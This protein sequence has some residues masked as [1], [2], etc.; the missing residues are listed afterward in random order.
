MAASW[1]HLSVLATSAA[2]VSVT[3]FAS[4]PM[5]GAAVASFVGA[6]SF[7]PSSPAEPAL[8]T[9]TFSPTTTNDN[10][11]LLPSLAAVKAGSTNATVST[12][13]GAAVWPNQADAFASDSNTTSTG[14]LSAGVLSAG[15]FF[16]NVPGYPSK[17]TGSVDIFT[18][19]S[20]S[21]ADSALSF[22][23]QQISTDKSSFFYHKA[24]F[25][26][27]DGDGRSDVIAARCYVPQYGLRK[28]KSELLW[29][30][31]PPA[32]SGSDAAW[33]EHV[34]L[35]SGPD[36]G[37]VM[38]DLD[39]GDGSTRSPQVVA[40]E[41]FV[42]QQLALYW[43]DGDGSGNGT[44]SECGEEGGSL[45]AVSSAVI[46]DTEGAMFNLQWVDLNGD[47][48]KDLLVTSQGDNGEGLVLGYERPSGDWRAPGAAWTKHV[49]ADGY[50]PL[51]AYLPG[52]GSPGTAVAFDF[53]SA[54][55]KPWVVV[56]ADDGG[57]VDMLVPASPSDP[58]NW[59][60]A[61]TRVVQSTGTVGTPA[62]GDADGDGTPEL[63][64]PLYDEGRL[65]MYSIDA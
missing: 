31:R 48:T 11:F 52:R 59:E 6:G 45:A 37:F 47:G 20:S 18:P 12:V 50:K 65:A 25:L 34:L 22:E 33:T 36:V 55:S 56:S 41:Y 61:K 35:S 26:D 63:F 49:L 17:A 7:G 53:S 19:W 16:V 28:D 43:C 4:V 39:G 44:W 40:T 54:A 8:L 51:K 32:G 60:Y 10:I 23:K 29:M 14:A 24:A 42:N 57:W 62:I 38:V 30:E 58:S 27:A 13:D 5:E 64:V 2:A 15:G 21:S 1:W 3:E 46:D 9:T